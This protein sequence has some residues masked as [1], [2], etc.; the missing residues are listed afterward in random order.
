MLAVDFLTGSM[1]IYS[2]PLKIGNLAVHSRVLQ[3]PLSGVTDLVFRR[4][5]RRFAPDS[6]LY[7]SMVNAT[8]ISQLQELPQLM[9]I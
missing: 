9:V 5:V 1:A 6:M 3:S 2:S 8:E 4:L 7:R